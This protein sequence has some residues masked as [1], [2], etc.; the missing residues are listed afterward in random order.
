MPAPTLAAADVDVLRKG[1]SGDVIRPGDAAYD[2]ARLLWNGAFDRRPAVVVRC[3]SAQDVSAAV[4][5]ARM[6]GLELAVRGGGHSTGGLSGVDDGLVIDLSAM[7][8]VETDVEGRRCRVG[9]G[10]TLGHRD[11]A[12][13]EHG[14]ATT[15]GIVGHTGVGGLTLTGGMGW[16]TRKHGLA[17]DNVLAVQIVTADG[18]I[19]RA[20]ADEEPDLYWAVRGG[21]GNFGVVTE[22]EFQLHPVGP[23]V[24][25]G[26]LFWP[27]TQAL[28]VLRLAR[29]LFASMSTETNIIVAGINAPPEPFVPAEHHGAPGIALVIAGFGGDGEHG[30][31]LE[32]INAELPPLFQ[33]TMPMP[34][35]GLQQMFDEANRFGLLAYDKA[36]YV[37]D[38]SDDVAAVIADQL[39]RK[40]SPRSA[41]FIYRLDGAYSEIGDDDTAFG[42][43]RSPR[44][45]VFLLAI[46]EE[47]AML[48]TDTRWARE[49]WDALQPVSMGRGSY[50]NGE[51]EYPD[52]RVR[53][54]FGPEK[55]A[56][57]AALKARYD[58]G[59]VFHRNANIPPAPQPPQQ[60]T[61][62]D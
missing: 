39:T 61:P 60:R 46:A 35:A 15:A 30:Q 52:D 44:Y 22:F 3:L 40:Q 31:V 62:G 29:R 51:A 19:R 32:Q 50:L 20:S 16:L 24:D 28:D 41:F 4:T 27:I 45:A 48:A 2:E 54:S 8:Q 57:L 59:N 36:T 53:A 17:L 34:Y 23:M 14:L 42:G 12:T 13:Q 26:L 5:F 10:A 1:V 47:P 56:R 7:N 11:G 43:G 58:P 25:F 18:K 37:E 33:L 21:G 49:F 38:L 6:H 9:G 55:Y